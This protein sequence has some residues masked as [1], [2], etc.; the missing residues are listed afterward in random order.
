R[1]VLRYDRWMA[2]Q[3][4]SEMARHQAAHQVVGAAGRVADMDR[5]S[6]ANEL[7]RAGRRGGRECKGDQR[8]LEPSQHCRV[9]LLRWR[10]SDGS[11]ERRRAF[12]SQRRDDLVAD[13]RDL[14]MR[15]HEFQEQELDAELT[16]LHHLLANFFRWADT[17][18]LERR[19]NAG[20][21]L[22]AV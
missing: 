22:A 10:P 6:L 15:R 7:L 4:P 1:H 12:G 17:A 16:E 14:V 8:G 18:G 19:E 11:R 5:D 3:M 13:A 21:D 2:R 9:V 20:A